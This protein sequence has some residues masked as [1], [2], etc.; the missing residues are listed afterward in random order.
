VDERAAQDQRAVRA[1]VGGDGRAFAGLVTRYQ[2]MAASVAW[3]YGVRGDEVED[4]VSEI[5]IKVYRNLGQYRPEHPF[6]TW[7]YRLA[8]NQVLDH[9]R[10][11]R[12]EGP[13]G[14]M[15]LTLEDPGPGPDDCALSHERSRMV[16][17]ALDE[18]P[19]R[20][21][22]ALFLVYIE[23][24][25]VEEAARTLGLPQGTIKSRLLRGREALRRI[26]ARRN[27]E[28]FGEGNALPHGA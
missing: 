5:F 20:Y 24:L 23:G 26:L 2:K 12:R 25:R 4:V 16:R 21:R 3:R 18:V 11:R 13:R 15:P 27:P 14:E 28:L 17:A 19:P 1:A 10:K 8:V 9:G 7:L 22:N 6:G